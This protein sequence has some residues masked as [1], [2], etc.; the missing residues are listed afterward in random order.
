[1]FQRSG[2]EADGSLFYAEAGAENVSLASLWEVPLGLSRVRAKS[3]SSRTILALSS[4]RERRSLS[5]MLPS[6]SA[7]TLEC[8]RSQIVI[9][10][11]L[12][13]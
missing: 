5:S 7:G 1:M 12:Y 11:K 2:P 6:L 4:S 8:G 10:P 13:G 9:E 3:H